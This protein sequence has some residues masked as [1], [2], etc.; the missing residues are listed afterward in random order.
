M[1]FVE[2]LNQSNQIMFLKEG[3]PRNHHWKTEKRGVNEEQWIMIY[4]NKSVKTSVVQGIHENWEW[5]HSQLTILLFK[6]FTRFRYFKFVG[7]DLNYIGKIWK[8][9]IYYKNWTNLVDN[10]RILTETE[11]KIRE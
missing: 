5:N 6:I 8:K 7:I 10:V 3:D 11:G 4:S 9:K 1:V 2:E